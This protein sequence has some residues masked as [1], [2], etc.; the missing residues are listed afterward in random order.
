[1]ISPKTA[2]HKNPPYFLTNQQKLPSEFLSTH[3]ST[4]SHFPHTPKKRQAC[5]HI[6][7]THR[8][9]TSCNHITITCLRA[10]H[11]PKEP[12]KIMLQVTS[13]VTQNGYHM[14]IYGHTVYWWHTN[15]W[16]VK[17]FAEWKKYELAEPPQ[18][19]EAPTLTHVSHVNIIKR[20]S[21]RKI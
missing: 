9:T 18:N 19:R 4:P 2:I 17:Y 11:K 14:L 20:N 3:F 16:N 15:S 10:T 21:D 1:M 6:F 7:W 8:G 13:S 12:V 5:C